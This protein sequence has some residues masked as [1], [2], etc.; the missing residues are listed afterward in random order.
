[1]VFVAVRPNGVTYLDTA[2]NEWKTIN[3]TKTIGEASVTESVNDI[4]GKL[5]TYFDKNSDVDMKDLGFTIE[6]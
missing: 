6:E 2:D 3:A 4:V 5:Q 1:M